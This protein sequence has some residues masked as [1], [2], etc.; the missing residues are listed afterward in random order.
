MMHKIGE[1]VSV[2]FI[3]NHQSRQASPRLIKWQN[4]IYKIDRLG[5]HYTLYQGSTLI[6]MFAVSTKDSFFLLS[7]NT[8]TLVWRLEEIADNA[9]N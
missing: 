1:D 8:K 5:L 3:Y 6:H 7:F 4:R 2:N 9:T